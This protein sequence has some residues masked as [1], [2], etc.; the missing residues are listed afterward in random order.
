LP[1]PG[2]VVVWLLHQRTSS[3]DTVHPKPSCCPL[4]CLTLKTYGRLSWGA[5]PE[6]LHSPY[7]FPEFCPQLY[8][9]SLSEVLFHHTLL[10]GN[11]SLPWPW[12]TQDKSETYIR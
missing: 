12:L 9:W 3:I 4:L 7:D 5:Q 8:K 2:E 11:L 6:S 1:S 10:E